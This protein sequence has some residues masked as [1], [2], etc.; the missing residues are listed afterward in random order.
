MSQNNLKER[1]A[2]LEKHWRRTIGMYADN[3][4]MKE[5]FDDAMK[6]READRRKARRRYAR[7]ARVAK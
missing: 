6:I 5:F 4:G 1:V 3:E 2:E 7:K